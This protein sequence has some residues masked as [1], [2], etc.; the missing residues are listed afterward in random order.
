MKTLIWLLFLP[1]AALNVVYTQA[2]PPGSV[3]LTTVYATSTANGSDVLNL[4]DQNPRT[5]WQAHPSAGP[6]EGILIRFAVPTTLT[7]LEA[8]GTDGAFDPEGGLMDLSFDGKTIYQNVIGQKLDLTGATDGPVHELYIRITHTNLEKPLK[9]EVGPW[10]QPGN[11]PPIGFKS[12]RLFG[13]KGQELQ[14]I[15]PKA[16]NGTVKASSS[17][18]PA[19][20]YGAERLF[21]A[22]LGLAWVEGN[23]KNAGVAETLDVTFD[24]PV[25]ITAL[26]SRNGYQRT[27]ESFEDNARIKAFEFGLDGATS[28]TYLLKDERNAQHIALA[29]PLSGNHFQLRIKQVYPGKKYTDLALSELVFYDGDRPFILRPSSTPASDLETRAAKTPLKTILNRGCRATTGSLKQDFNQI[30]TLRGDGTF[31]FQIIAT[32]IDESETIQEASGHWELIEATPNFAKVKITGSLQSTVN[33]MDQPKP[34]KTTVRT[35]SEL[36][37]IDQNSLRGQKIVQT[38]PLK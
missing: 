22:N 2:L 15:A 11:L 32:T 16:Q 29:A 5:T 27:P 33:W 26:Q 18:T 1:L 12:L 25:R 14:L 34:E 23:P 9:P 36:L 28:N 4:F 37:S 38:I 10:F 30:F 21:D 19:Y 31:D 8:I 3:V 13:D 35:F 17:L 20:A 6:G 24:Q 7:G